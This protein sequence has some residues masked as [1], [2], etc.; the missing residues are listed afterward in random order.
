MKEKAR[1]ILLLALLCAPVW[2][3]ADIIGQNPELTTTATLLRLCLQGLIKVIPR[4]LRDF[5]RGSSD[6]IDISNQCGS[7]SCWA[8][9]GTSML[10]KQFKKETG[11]TLDISNSAVLGAHYVDQ[12]RQ[13]MNAMYEGKNL[14]PVSSLEIADG[15]NFVQA[16]S[17]LT[18][19]GIGLDQDVKLE[20]IKNEGNRIRF[21]QELVEFL[22]EYQI[23]LAAEK[24]KD[25]S[26]IQLNQ[27]VGGWHGKLKKLLMEKLGF[28]GVVSHIESFEIMIQPNRRILLIHFQKTGTKRLGIDFVCKKS[29]KKV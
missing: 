23:A 9:V 24:A 21:K 19:Y 16:L 8:H 7:G 26:S 10:R 1:I 12:V 29:T 28:S 27:F 18:F 4:P 15:A 25:P 22:K 14:E 17:A 11:D 13:L 6:Y 20:L 3:A 5:L 2:A